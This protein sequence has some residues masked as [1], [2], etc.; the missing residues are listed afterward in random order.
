MLEANLLGS[1]D[2]I[3]ELCTSAVKE[4]QIETKLAG[5]A[6]EWAD[7]ELGFAEYKNKGLCIL[8]A[9]ETAEL[10]EKLEDS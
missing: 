9:G 10:I 1:R 2:I 8:K 6:A 3:E 7:L 4:E 5:I